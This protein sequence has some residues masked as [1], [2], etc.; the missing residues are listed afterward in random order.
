MNRKK[1][2]INYKQKR[3]IDGDSYFQKIHLHIMLSQTRKDKTP[4][5]HQVAASKFFQSTQP[6]DITELHKK[7]EKT[8]TGKF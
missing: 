4:C 6:Y 1:T 7:R 2:T 5:L 3:K 8:K